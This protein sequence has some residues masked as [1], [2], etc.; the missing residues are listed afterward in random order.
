MWYG[1]YSTVKTSM[2]PGKTSDMV[3][4]NELKPS[5]VSDYYYYTSANPLQLKPVGTM[6]VRDTR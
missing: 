3:F 5:D 6:D 1:R 2:R 4:L